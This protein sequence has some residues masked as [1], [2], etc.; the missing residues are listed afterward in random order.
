MNDRQNQATLS[1]GRSGWCVIFR[2]PRAKA[3]DQRQ[4]LRVRRGL[5]TANEVEAQRLVD[6]L[7]QI[8][9]DPE[10]QTLASRGK[11]ALLFDPRIVS[12]YYDHLEASSRDTW[13]ERERL[14]PLPGSKEG[15]AKVLLV[16]TTGSGKTTLARQLIGTDPEN[17]RFPSTSAAKT[18]TADIELIL[19]N[20]EYQAVVSF[21]SRDVTRQ[22]IV[23]CV[24]ASIS[25]HI[26]SAPT[27]EIVRRF[28][29]HNEMRFR[30]NY[31][32]GSPSFSAPGAGS[33]ELLDEDP[34]G[35]D[36]EL[37]D[38]SADER[39]ENA[40]RLQ[41][42]LRRVAWL[43]SVYREKVSEA[44]RDFQID[45][46]KIKSQ[47]RDA[48]QELV[49]EQLL[50]SEAFDSLVDDILE[51]TES[52]FALVSEWG[53]EKGRD[54]WPVLWHYRSENRETFIRMVNRFSSN[55]AP[56]F[57][58]LLTPLV[59]GIRV[60]GP[61]RPDWHDENDPVRLVLLDGQGI[62][63]TAD[64]STSIST[65][66]TR[67]FQISDAIVLVDNAAQPMQAG[68][69]AVLNTLVSS[70]HE[71][72]L[73]VCFTHFDDLKDAPNL[74]GNGEKQAHIVSS[75]YS[76]VRSIGQKIGREA[77]HALSRLIPD[78]LV[79]VAGIQE[80]L[81]PAKRFTRAELARLLSLIRASI[82]PQPPTSLQPSYDIAKLGFPI[83][84][85]L[86][87]F[88]ETWNRK[89]TAEHWTRIK[90]LTRRLG[91]FRQEEYAE[92]KPVA[93]LILSLQQEISAFLSEPTG[94]NR[95][96]KRDEERDE[97]LAVIDGIRQVLFGRLHA[98]A[99]ERVL[100]GKLGE[101][102]VAFSHRGSGSSRKRTDDIRTIYANAAPVPNG[103]QGVDAD[104]FLNA[105]REFVAAAVS[106]AGGKVPGWTRGHET[107]VPPDSGGS[108]R[109]EQ[110][111]TAATAMPKLKGIRVSQLAKELNVSSM[112]ILH[113]LKK[114]Q[115]PHPPSNPQSTISLDMADTVRKWGLSASIVT[116]PP[117]SGEV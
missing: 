103:P 70:G 2:H 23:D 38:V 40:Q 107:T 109:P 83:Q 30:L 111:S 9:G 37:A 39:K 114:R 27:Q 99:H 44:V 96:V 41:E 63:H 18:T 110:V 87:T 100:D 6:E 47:D 79:F 105:I 28:T 82:V 116:P 32:L 59:D 90:A 78:R 19:S 95:P 10:M 12:A 68:S 53:Y 3:A 48:L 66:I 64:T 73:L 49:E 97:K 60:R 46:E 54:G 91:I 74:P 76:V 43:A 89:L 71:S 85:A 92:L 15:Y 117:A 51:D 31:L 61:F 56:N 24:I 101:W 11:A 80:P 72:K 21:V 13:S 86:Q 26:E 16:G 81:S 84:K 1:K 52:R 22:Y 35:G 94:W 20:G 5:G 45:L 112:A 57:G 25:G 29:E 93:D 77:E 102:V 69:A 42:Y 14:L 104:E 33:T 108:E 7:N 58:R 88:H 115:V 36:A 106:G 50:K 75:Y 67:R 62:G 8:L 34:V 65:G 4:S 113:E 55:Y 17:E 98:F